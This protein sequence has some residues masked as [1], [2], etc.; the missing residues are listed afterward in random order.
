MYASVVLPL[1]DCPALGVRSSVSSAPDDVH[2]HPV[3]VIGGQFGAGVI[4]QFPEDGPMAVFFVLAIAADRE[5][6][7]MG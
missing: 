5:I 1:R 2:V 7:A 3:G 4:Q 6:G